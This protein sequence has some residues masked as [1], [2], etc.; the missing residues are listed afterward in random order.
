MFYWLLNIYSYQKTF[1]INKKINNQYIIL[2]E[3]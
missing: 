1:T 3:G 2:S